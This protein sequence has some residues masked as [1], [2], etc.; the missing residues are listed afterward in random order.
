MGDG[1]VAQAGSS[2]VSI[3]GA[4]IY[5]IVGIGKFSGKR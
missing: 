5:P 3:V 1:K 2:G 4:D